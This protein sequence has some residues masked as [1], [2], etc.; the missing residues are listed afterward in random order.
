MATRDSKKNGTGVTAVDSGSSPDKTS[1]LGKAFAL[2]EVMVRSRDPMS[3]GAMASMLGMPKTTLHRVVAQLEQL[4]YLQ[5]EPGTRRFTLGALFFRLG[6]EAIS[7]SGNYFQRH[8]ILADLANELGASCCIGIRVGYEIVYLD[9]VAAE[10]AALTLR[11]R[12]G[13]RAPLHCTSQGKLYLAW[14][15]EQ[16]LEQFLAT[17][18]LERFA[19][20]TITDP[21]ELRR[22][23]RS[24]A[25]TGFA[26]STE[27]FVPGICGAAVPVLGADRRIYATLSFAAPAAQ[28]DEVSLRKTRAALEAAA[29][30]LADALGR[31]GSKAAT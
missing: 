28:L 8:A 18:T 17:C 3:L 4:G 6:L 11:F 25:R 21:D 30:K 13:L 26:T 31:P 16:E 5:R 2:L 24:I 22:V 12:S 27:E 20:N 1:P 19:P 10:N 15:A 9:D 7:N 29:L 14:M 23:V